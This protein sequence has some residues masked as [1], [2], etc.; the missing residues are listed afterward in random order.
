MPTPVAPRPGRAWFA[1]VRA[2][3]VVEHADVRTDPAAL[4]T[5]GWWAVVGTFEGRVDA[6]RFAEVV[7]GAGADAPVGDPAAWQGPQPGGWRTSLDREAYVAAVDRVRHHVREGDV[8]QANLCRVLAAPLPAGPAGPD[9]GAL[10]ARL[11]AGNPAP[12]AGGVHVPGGGADPACW[13]VTAS[14]ELY[15]RLRDGELTSAPIKG[16][17]ATAD[18]LTAKD[19]AENVMITDL[20]RNDLQRVCRPGTVRV[21]SLL[22]VEHHPGLAHLVSTV[23]GTLADDVRAAP[24]LV[25]RVLDATYPPGSVSGAPK[26]SALRVIDALETVP[27]GPYCGVVGWVH[28]GDD[29][30]VRAELA[31]GIRTFWWAD[32]VLRFGTG[33]GITWHSDP[34]R[35]W[36][37]TELKA[38][39][40]VGLASAAHPPRAGGVPVR[41]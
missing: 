5:P 26:S 22:E 36:D 2:S 11:E 23:T 27:R 14:P 1:G 39:R 38:A 40:L 8:Y 18:G 30:D 15:L 4:T 32:D 20:V 24:D 13:V 7:T 25:A 6:W 19:R 34:L 12:Y 29:G 21:T 3:G 41:G 37:E 17:A 35:E 31:V 10:A 33:A 28:V 9:A 16:T